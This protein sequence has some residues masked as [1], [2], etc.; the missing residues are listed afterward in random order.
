MNLDYGSQEESKHFSLNED[1]LD[2]D[3]IDVE[4][5]NERAQKNRDKIKQTKKNNLIGDDDLDN[6]K[7]ESG[8]SVSGDENIY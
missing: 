5:Q 7:N 1:D 2:Q 3:V 6:F 8:T 4:M